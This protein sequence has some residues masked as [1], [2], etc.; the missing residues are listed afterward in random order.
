M[1]KSVKSLLVFALVAVMVFLPLSTGAQAYLEG[2]ELLNA[3]YESNMRLYSFGADEMD[4]SYNAQPSDIEEFAAL[5]AKAVEVTAGLSTDREKAEAINRWVA[6]N[7]YYDYD[8]Y[9]HHTKGAP[10]FAPQVVFETGIAVC[11]G[12]ARLTAAMLCAA[13]IPSRLVCGSTYENA[14]DF[15]KRSTNH[16]W[17]EVYFDGEWNM[18]DPTWDS[19]NRYEYG[20]KV[21]GAYREDYFAMDKRYFSER[22]FIVKYD[23]DLKIGDLIYTVA[24][25]DFKIKG[26][27]GDKSALE[28]LVV[29]EGTTSVGSNA[30]IDSTAL[31]RVKLPS[32]FEA[33]SYSAF[34]NCT[35]LE[36]VEINSPIKTI[37]Q[38]AFYGCS[39]LSSFTFSD[40]LTSIGS[41]AFQGCASLE[42]VV[43]P[44]S[45]TALGQSVF[46]DC[47]ALKTVHIGTG[48]T[49]LPAD[50][51]HNCSNLETITGGENIVK[52]GQYCFRYCKKYT[53]NDFLMNLNYMGEYA[54]QGCSMVKRFRLP[55]YFVN[56]PSNFANMSSLEEVVI[57][58]DCWDLPDN[59]FYGC[60]K[61][62]KINIPASI[63]HFGNGVFSNCSALESITVPDG[64]TAIG[65]STFYF[66]TSLKSVYIPASVTEIG[67][68]AFYYCNALSTVYYSGTEEQWNAITINSGNDALLKANIVF[69]HEHNFSKTVISEATCTQSGLDELICKDCG[70]KKTEVQAQGSHKYEVTKI[71][72]PTC[73]SDGFTI[74][75]CTVCGDTVQKD[76][77]TATGHSFTNYVSNG[78]ATCTA[79]GTK[80]AKCDR[81]DVTDTVTE[82][83]TKLGH[84]FTNY[85]SNRDAT[86]TADGTKTA[87]CDRCDVTDTVTEKNTKLG[88]SFT[89]Y[90]SDKNATCTADGT[91]TAKCDRCDVTNTVTD[92]GSAK[93]HTIVIDKTVAPT[94]TKTGHTEGKHCSVCNTV[95][96]KQEVI[97][98]TG[99][100]DNNSDEICDSCGED[101]GTH[102]PSENC[103]CIC[104]K[105]GFAGFIYKIVRFFWKLFRIN[106]VCTCGQA[107]Y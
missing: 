99:H 24:V 41:G 57:S 30:F 29:P 92:E 39:S 42:S 91:K 6:E 26:Y 79:D 47:T 100:N 37:E 7:V 18:C 107:H 76:V 63:T 75:T 44:E 36:T 85:V 2:T 74:C 46:K 77:V 43:L 55:R 54:L 93:G 11:E 25:D 83:N 88:H 80:T 32:T 62:T 68:K 102:T 22:H 34:K 52:I 20:Q 49:E 98:A 71:V 104:H 50:C 28:N 48:I 105:S 40:G 51:F 58:E 67:S 15:E 9:I 4:V 35:A 103:T 87:K 78:D 64:T 1:K 13:G 84:S 73:E 101:L 38:N 61:L 106:K 69:G 21:K 12:Y 65:D 94:C 3:V 45:M 90:V 10:S 16:E 95:L 27:S 81:C 53:G 82:K 96:V 8:Y 31:K 14:G 66:C 72:A 97:P 59:S 86:C 17:L 70:F 33:F 89:N 19:G 56:N 5:N 23:S 60:K